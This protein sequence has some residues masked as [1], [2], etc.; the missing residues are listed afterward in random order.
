AG[1]VYAVGMEEPDHHTMWALDLGSG[2]VIAS[3]RVDADG[4][5]PTVHNQRAALTLANGKVYV[6]Y[7]GRDRDCGGDKGRVGSVAIT[8]SGLGKVTSFTVASRGEAG[9]WTPPGASVAGDGSLFLASGNS[10]GRGDF[11]YGNAVIRLSPDLRVIDAF[12]PT[13]WETLDRG[14]V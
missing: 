13:N 8:A 3:K 1:R 7:G 4:A 5:D 2:L 6:P 14:D 9:F 10:S 12:A 11:D